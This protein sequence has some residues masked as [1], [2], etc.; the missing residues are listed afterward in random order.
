MICYDKGIFTNRDD[1]KV[2]E[3][4][5]I[6]GFKSV[7]V[8]ANTWPGY[9]KY[10]KKLQDIESKLFPRSSTAAIFKE[11]RF[12][13]LNH[14]DLWTNNM[15]FRYDQNGKPVDMRFVSHGYL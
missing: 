2:V 7:I 6:S 4:F 8:A 11:N 3:Q 9:E 1:N 13:V 15:L 12:N 10:G 14:G 5:V